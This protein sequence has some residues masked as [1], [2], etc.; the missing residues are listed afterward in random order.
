M[1]R[2]WFRWC[3]AAETVLLPFLGHEG[4]TRLDLAIDIHPDFDQIRGLRA[5]PGDE[6]IA[7]RSGGRN[8]TVTRQRTG[9][10]APQAGGGR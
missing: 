6:T 4:I 2:P 1:G 10:P 5:L 3:A 7:M 9:G 8:L